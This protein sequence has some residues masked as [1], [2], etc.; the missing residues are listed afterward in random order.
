[1][2]LKII[3]RLLK[4][5]R[6]SQIFTLGDISIFDVILSILLFV[7]SVEAIYGMT[8]FFYPALSI[9][10]TRADTAEAV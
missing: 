9:L 3:S 4:L 1:M 6:S 10:L 7:F 2:D 8:F 5:G